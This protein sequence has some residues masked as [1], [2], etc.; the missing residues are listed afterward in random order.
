MVLRAAWTALG[1]RRLF[2]RTNHYPLDVVDGRQSGRPPTSDEGERGEDVPGATIDDDAQQQ[3]DAVADGGARSMVETAAIVTVNPRTRMR[4]LLRKVTVTV[5][6]PL[7]MRR[8]VRGCGT[9][10]RR[11]EQSKPRC[12]YVPAG[13]LSVTHWCAPWLRS[14]CPL[15][16]DAALS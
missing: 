14:G 1:V 3:L 2:Q 7:V 6:H 10:S 11:C 4:G 8:F 5:T 9:R 12:N 16:R 15:T 13:I